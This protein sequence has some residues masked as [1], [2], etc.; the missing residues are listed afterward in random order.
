MNGEPGIAEM[1]WADRRHFPA[2]NHG[3]EARS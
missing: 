1:K 2:F 3:S